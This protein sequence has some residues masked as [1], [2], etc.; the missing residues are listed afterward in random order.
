[1]D[2][3]SFLSSVVEVAIGIAG[4]AGIVA[5]IRQRNV[6]SWPPRQL[7]QLQILF[8]ASAAAVV[9][10]ILPSFLAEAG[11]SEALLWKVCSATLISWLIGAIWY[12]ARQGKRYGVGQPIPGM[13]MAWGMAA[14][15]LQAYNLAMP[16]VSWPYLF[17]VTGLLMNGFSAF[18]VLILRPFDDAD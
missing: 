7:I 2:A 11:V 8:A 10:G 17:G 3:G 9:A 4:F 6:S 12:R 16:G 15:V 14:I 18:L 5:A 13:V 1:M